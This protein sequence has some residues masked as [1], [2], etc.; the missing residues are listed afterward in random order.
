MLNLEIIAAFARARGIAIVTEA[1]G[2]KAGTSKN[3]PV[4]D[5][6]GDVLYGLPPRVHHAAYKLVAKQ[7][8]LGVAC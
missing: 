8:V 3:M 5:M 4:I 7:P 2:P 1:W 6:V